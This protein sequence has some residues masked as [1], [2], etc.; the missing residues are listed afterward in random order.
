MT[1]I[2][3]INPL[4]DESG[5]RLRPVEAA[6]AP[7]IFALVDADR[8]R[9][10]RR[11]P[12]VQ[13]CRTPSDTVGFVA[14]S[15]LRRNRDEGGDGSGDWAIEVPQEA[16]P[17]VVGVIGLHDT[18]L[19]QHRTA[20]GYWISSTFAERGYATRAARLVTMHCLDRGLH[21]IEINVAIDNHPSRAIAERLGF[22]LEGVARCAEWIDGRA[23]DHAVYALVRPTPDE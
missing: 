18:R 3:L 15:V 21:R 5:M 13:S 4:A 10:S 19:S 14:D 7:G 23:I 22:A 11:L 1:D 16:G 8:E 17:T 2:P 20:I 6:H 12:W 9:L